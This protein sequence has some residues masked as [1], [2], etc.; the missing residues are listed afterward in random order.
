MINSREIIFNSVRN[1]G[2]KDGKPADEKLILNHSVRKGENGDLLILIG[3]N[4]S[5]K[6]N[7]LDGIQWSKYINGINCQRE[8]KRCQREIE[9]CQGEIESCQ[10]NIYYLKIE[11]CQKAIESCQK[12]IK[13]TTNL[14]PDEAC[15]E[16]DVSFHFTNAYLNKI[17]LADIKKEN[18][19]QL[20]EDE[21]FSKLLKEKYSSLYNTWY[22]KYISKYRYECKYAVNFYFEAGM[23][24][25]KIDNPSPEVR[26]FSHLFLSEYLTTP[27]SDEEFINNNPYPNC[28]NANE[29][30][31]DLKISVCDTKRNEIFA[32]TFESSV[33]S[34]E[35]KFLSLYKTWCKKSGYGFN[36]YLKDGMCSLKI[37][38]LWRD[39]YYFLDLF[40][41]EYLTTSISDEDFINNNPYYPRNLSYEPNCYNANEAREIKSSEFEISV[42]EIGNSEF[43][44][45]LLRAI[46][47]PKENVI[48]AYDNLKKDNHRKHLDEL[49]GQI[50][51]SLE[52]ISEIFNQFYV[53]DAQYSFK[54]ELEREN[55]RF[56]IYRGNDV[57][58][59]DKQS[60]GFRYFFNL[61]IYLYSCSLKPGDIIVMDEPA[62]N[63][64]ISAQKELRVFLKEIAR[65]W[66][67]TIVLAT[68]SPFLID[69]DH[70]DELRII[71]N[72]DNIVRIHNTFTVVNYGDPD[73]LLPIKEA[74]TV[75]N[76]ILVNPENTVVFVEGITDYNYLTAFKLL[77]K[78]ED[79]IF[80]PINGV[81]ADENHCKEI[82]KK[83]LKIRKDAIVLVDN[84]TAGQRMKEINDEA[85]ELKVIS[86]A[87]I[88]K[89]F[90]EIESLFSKEDLRKCELI[91]GNGEIIKHASTSA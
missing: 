82:S 33:N 84:D 74:L 1:I 24:S 40:L 14:Y 39:E 89:N 62:T 12:A 4:N 67:I 66:D 80:V 25:L 85:S 34:L 16:P 56:F 79:I 75:E 36:V 55:I 53:T 15:R 76:H 38:K 19:R 37:D 18:I 6:S 87:D 23:C 29:D 64:H 17:K 30:I 7:I 21:V 32:D 22:R 10:G 70:L 8:I 5:G 9:H 81:G 65:C 59:L 54:M 35:K 44:T 78:N 27:I 52:N 3:A 63:L 86:L 73:S 48:N 88:D 71:E 51:D 90:K 41:S 2:F 11:D 77:F 60:V 49:Q 58:V 43:F 72:K 61:F 42:G 20:I 68:H 57:M 83:L 46:E 13:F 28:G 69:L 31:S 26:Y 91:D 50:N 45:A 47:M